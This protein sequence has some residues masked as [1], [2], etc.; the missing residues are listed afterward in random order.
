[1]KRG[2]IVKVGRDILD[3]ADLGLVINVGPGENLLLLPLQSEVGNR[4][5]RWSVS[6]TQND[7]IGAVIS[8]RARAIPESATTV[9]AKDCEV[10]DS[11]KND[12]LDL[13]L[14]K[15]TE[16]AANFYYQEF[17]RNNA[18]EQGKTKVNYSGRVYDEREIFA[19]INSAL[20]FWLTAGPYARQFEEKMRDFLGSKKFYL[21]NS[22]SSAN[23]VMVA[24]LCSKQFKD[25]LDPGDEMITPAVTFPTTLT[26]ILQNNLVPVFVDCEVGTYNVNP[27]LIEEAIGPKT[28]AIFIPAP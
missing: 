3:G 19:L 10:V 6:L 21:V 5:S 8:D 14:R 4:A 13:C 9:A 17:H 7:V 23:L 27:A 2:D 18:F 1:M 12:A 24:G 15:F 28:R 22:G 11:L 25:H 26:P 20:D 16:L